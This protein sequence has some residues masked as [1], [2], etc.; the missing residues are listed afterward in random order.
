MVV[1]KEMREGTELSETFIEKRNAGGKRRK[2]D[3]QRLERD[4]ENSP[5]NL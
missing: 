3:T 1:G 2:K 4:E 5:P